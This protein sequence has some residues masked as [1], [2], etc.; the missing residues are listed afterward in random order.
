MSTARE[1]V[2]GID[3][4]GT[5]TDAVLLDY[6]SRKVLALS[7]TLTTR[8]N[9]TRGITKALRNLR[10]EETGKVR[11]VGVS[12]TLATNSIAEGKERTAGLLLIGYDRDLITAY[13][14]AAKF[15]TTHWAPLGAL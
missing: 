3:T 5:Y 1:Y 10:I 7:K 9:L 14:L 4:G 11:L 6:R 8:D 12:S 13:D 15:P 2:I